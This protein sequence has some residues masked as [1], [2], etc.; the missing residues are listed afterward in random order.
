[1]RKS[2]GTLVLV[3]LVVYL[4]ATGAVVMRPKEMVTALSALIAGIVNAGCGAHKTTA[5]SQD[6]AALE[7][8][9]QGDLVSNR[10]SH[11]GRERHVDPGVLDHAEVLG[12]QAGQFGGSFLGQ[13]SLFP[14]VPKAQAESTLGRLDRLPQPRAKP[15]L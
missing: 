15:G 5:S 13:L 2:I 6:W 9:R 11:E 10:E 14:E 8:R 12:V 4:F 1:M 3:S 7:E